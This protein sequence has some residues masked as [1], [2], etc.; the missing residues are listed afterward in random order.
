MTTR[1]TTPPSRSSPATAGTSFPLTCNDDGAGCTGFTSIAA[2]SNV[3]AGTDLFI[4]IGGYN[5]SVGTGTVT[6]TSTPGGGGPANDE[7]SGAVPLVNGTSQAY[8]T[9]SAST[10]APAWP[11]AGG[12]GSDIWYSYTTSALSDVT[13]E[14]CGSSYDTAIEIFS[15]DCSSS[16]PSSATTTSAASRAPRPRSACRLAPSSASASGASPLAAGRARCCSFDRS[17]QP[18]DSF[19]D[20]DTCQTASALTTGIYQGLFCSLTDADFYEVSLGANDILDFVIFDTPNE[21]IDLNLYD[22]S[23]NLINFFDARRALLPAGGTAQTVIVE[24]FVDPNFA[25]VGCLN[26]DIDMS[27]APTPARRSGPM[28]SRR[29]TTARPPSPSRTAATPV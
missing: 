13:V 24:V 26:Y 28:P 12:G 16:C 1:R 4:R 2:A 11:C 19:E 9:T 15:G 5:G 20:N 21:D 6:L 22:S 18:D 7:C 23:C 25:G 10:S 27:V 3:A 8:D 29:T 17:T 14:T